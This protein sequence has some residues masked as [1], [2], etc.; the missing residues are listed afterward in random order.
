MPAV[1]VK[2]PPLLFSGE[3]VRA[4]LAGENRQRKK[5]YPREGETPVSDAH[6]IRRLA[7]G[8]EAAPKD[9]CWNWVKTCKAHGYGTLT[10]EGR[11]IYA[12]RLAFRLSGRI[13]RDG[14]QVRHTCD[15]PRCINP[16][17]LLAG[18]H[19]DN[20]QDM[21]R[22]GRH[23][24]PPPPTAGEKNPAS[25]LTEKG[26]QEIRVRLRDGEVQRILAAEYG[27]SQSQISNIKRGAQWR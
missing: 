18:N 22:R 12:H 23:P 1:S 11:T 25:R 9:G 24:G 5:L 2:E 4:S 8:L 19:S 13:L 7:N 21:V 15:N 14:Q 27:V 6:L 26:V 20:M 17:H 3:M 16:A 10:L